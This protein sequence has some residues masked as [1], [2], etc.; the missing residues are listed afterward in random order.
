M[1]KKNKNLVLA[2]WILLAIY[3]AITLLIGY[4]LNK[5][6]FILD[7]TC[8]T[9]DNFSHLTRKLVGLDRHAL[10]VWDQIEEF[11]KS[12]CVNP[13]DGCLMWLDEIKEY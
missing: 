4:N 7:K 13:S 5:T 3:T 12:E 10:Q 11:Q 1:N 9:N 2:R 8:L 6:G